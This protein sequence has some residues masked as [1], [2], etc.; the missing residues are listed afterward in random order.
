MKLLF[1]YIA[2][3][4]QTLHSLPVALEIANNYPEFE[5]HIVCTTSSHLDYIKSL[6]ALYPEVKLHYHRFNLTRLLRYQISTYGINAVSKLL[7]LYQNKAFFKQFDAIIVP[8]RTSLLLRKLGVKKPKLIW[9]RHGAG[10]RAIGFAKDVRNFDFI[11]MA[12]KKIE[13]RLLSEAH[14]K[15]D[16]Y[17]TGI[18]AKFDIINRIQQNPIQLFNNNKPIV[19]YNPHFKNYLSSW[20]KFGRSILEQFANQDRYNLIFA[21]HFRLF[22]P[23]KEKHYK[24][25]SDCK[26]HP[27]ILIDLGSPRSIDMTYTL[28]ANVYLGDVSSQLSEFLIHPRPCVFLNA[29][30]IQWSN[31]IN[32]TSWTLGQVVSSPHNIIKVIDESFILQKSFLQSQKDYIRNTFGTLNSPTARIGADAIVDYLKKNFNV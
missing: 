18:Y 12:G 7:L 29:H 8:E 5:I 30:K 2:Q 10:D 23:V 1:S 26:N 28:A 11:L 32:Y 22:Y 3:P 16:K 17:K 31:D 24:T 6:A 19:L 21:P 9:T 25:F 4:H 14:I 15:E 20:P 27:N 13:K